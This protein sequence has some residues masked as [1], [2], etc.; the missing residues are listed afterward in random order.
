MTKAAKFLLLAFAIAAISGCGKKP[1]IEGNWVIDLDPMLKQAQE[2]GAT[3]ND[4]KRINTTYAGGKLNI[5]KERIELSIGGMPGTQSFDYKVLYQEGE[6]LRLQ[7]AGK[8]TKYCVNGDRL[9]IHDPGTRLI[10]VFK[11]S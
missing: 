1:N 2:I 9:Y 8:N 6:C 3:S 5:G 10:A 11:K 7:I 4:I